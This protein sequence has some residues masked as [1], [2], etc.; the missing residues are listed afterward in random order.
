MNAS[1]KSRKVVIGGTH[2]DFK[3]WL[4]DNKLPESAVYRATRAEHL[5]GLEIKQEDIV[6]LGYL[7][8]EAEMVLKTR[9][10]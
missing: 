2:Q 1:A 7:S 9:I 4:F 10:R 3:K 5:L 8:P 6:R